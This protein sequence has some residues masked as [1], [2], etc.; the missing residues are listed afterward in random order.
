M[1]S[2]TWHSSARPFYNTTATDVLARK[3]HQHRGKV[4]LSN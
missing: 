2:E 3:L 4:K 1:I